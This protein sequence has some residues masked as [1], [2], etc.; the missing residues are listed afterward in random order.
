MKWLPQRW[1]QLEDRLMRDP[2]WRLVFHFGE[3]LFTG[4]S[5]AGEGEVSLGIGAMLALLAT[6]G[7]FITVL[8]FD[9]YSSTIRFF[10][11]GGRFDAYA[12]S[13]PDQYF[14]FAFSMAITGVVTALKWDSIFPGRRDYMNLAPL[15]IPTRNIFLANITAIV[16]IAVF[17]AVDVNCVS[18]FLFPLLVNMEKGSFYDYVRFVGAQAL[19]VMLSS[20]FVFL[21]LFALAGTLMAILPSQLFRRLSLYIRV[22]VVTAMLTLL[23]TSAAV[24]Q[25][26]RDSLAFKSPVL[27]WLPPVWFLGFVRSLIH[28]T[29]ANLVQ[30][31]TFGVK[32]MG[33]AALLAGA[34]YGLSYYRYFIRIPETLDIPVRKREPRKLVPEWFLDRLL[35]RTPFERACYKFTLKTLARNERQSL[36]L[37]GFLGLGLVLASQTLIFAV[38]HAKVELP[39]VPSAEYLAL[40]LILAY[41]VICGLCFVFELPAELSANWAAQ[42]IVDRERHHAARVARKVTLSLVWP[43][44]L[45]IALPL[46]AHG[47]GWTVALGHIA[48]L[49]VLTY[50]LADWRLGDYRKIPFTC[51]YSPWKQNATVVIILY[52]VGYILFTVTVSEWEHSLLLRRPRYL[53]LLAGGLLAAW[54][55]YARLRRD[56]LD[57]TELIFEEEPVPAVE[58]LNLTGRLPQ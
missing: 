10:R 34:T 25:L 6:P 37:G 4:G 16:A 38:A 44:V 15:P 31:G 43:W 21:A 30:L 51:S 13:L 56:E 22:V 5:E 28:E 19:G 9:K 49:M 47:W 53:W 7:L 14:F 41:F 35:L 12:Q 11:G 24:P 2:F 17:F 54:T 26:L 18:T 36:F 3:R 32:M 55:V 27:L 40:P 42:V 39:G 52:A 57:P 46:Y 58:I 8:L 48:V 23:S 1:Q 45:L 33:I 29:D 20:L 50:C